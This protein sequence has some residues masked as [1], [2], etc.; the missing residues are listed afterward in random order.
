MNNLLFDHPSEDVRAAAIRLL[1]TLTT[2]ERTTG[3]ENLV[4]IKDSIGCGYRSLSGAPTPPNVTDEQ[5]LEA[6]SN[7]QG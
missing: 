1:D 7:I 5:M 6:F 3:R 2:W 4:I